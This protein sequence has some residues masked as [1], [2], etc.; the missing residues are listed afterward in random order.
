MP[1]SKKECVREIHLMVVGA[2]QESCRS[3]HLISFY[4]SEK[5]GEK[6]KLLPYYHSQAWRGGGRERL[7]ESGE[8]ELGGGAPQSGGLTQRLITS[9]IPWLR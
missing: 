8:L 7:L 2:Q 5:L 6:Q 4:I 9:A 1:R 3:L